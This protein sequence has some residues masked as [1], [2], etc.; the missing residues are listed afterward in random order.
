MARTVRTN[1]G[2]KLLSGQIRSR[3]GMHGHNRP[4][5]E[6]VLPGPMADSEVVEQIAQRTHA[7]EDFYVVFREVMR[8]LEVTV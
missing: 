7:G 2:A 8:K 1:L 4:E 3:P 6:P 5:R